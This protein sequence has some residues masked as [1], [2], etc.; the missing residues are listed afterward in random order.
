M[1]RNIRNNYQQ[2]ELSEKCIESDPL[3]QFQ[4]WLNEALDRK[5]AEPTAM[6]LSTVDNENRPHARVVLLK[7]LQA[8][9]LIFF[10]NHQSAKGQQILGNNTVS[11]TFFWPELEKQVR[12]EGRASVIEESVSDEYFKSRPH[13][14]QLGAWASPQ[15]RVIPSKEILDENFRLYSRRFGEE[16]PRPEYWGGFR[17]LPDYFEFWQG[18]PNRLHDRIR[19]VLTNNNWK[20][21]R[22][23][24]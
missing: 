12:I 15:S 7:D 21:E 4:Q 23:A 2:A 13:D 24:P 6:I 16:I 3:K 22:L 17:V 10:T 5:V 1:L 14:S 18:R 19:Y 11:L 9:G 8:D 20:I